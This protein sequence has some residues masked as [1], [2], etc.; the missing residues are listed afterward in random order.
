MWHLSANLGNKVAQLLGT[1]AGVRCLPFWRGVLDCF[2]QFVH[3]DHEALDEILVVYFAFQNFMDQCKVK[4][5][6]AVWS[7]L[8]IASGLTGGY[9]G[10]RI[11]VSTLHTVGDC[12]HEGLGLLDHQ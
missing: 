12:S 4:C 10:T 9:A 5:I 11:N 7:Y 6:V 3:T 2:A 8:P 1:D